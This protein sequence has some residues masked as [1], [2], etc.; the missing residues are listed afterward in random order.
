M[1]DVRLSTYQ[2][3]TGICRKPRSILKYTEFKANELRSL[4]IFGFPI[5]AMYLPAKFGRH[6]LLLATAANF[7]ESKTFCTDQISYIKSLVEEFIFEFPLLYGE[8][9]NVIS[10]HTVIH[11]T[12]SIKQ[13]GPVYNYS[14]FSF[15]SYLGSYESLG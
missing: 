8:R 2:F 15:E 3:P 4:L 10:I 13:F 12:E 5:L 7:C 11:L 9:E 14:T 6:F 1:I